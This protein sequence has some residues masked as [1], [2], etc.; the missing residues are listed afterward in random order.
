MTRS[1]KIRD[2]KDRKARE[3]AEQKQPEPGVV[4]VNQTE[5]AVVPTPIPFN[6]VQRFLASIEDIEQYVFG[7]VQDGTVIITEIDGHELAALYDGGEW[8]LG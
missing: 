7:D 5:M 4:E 1:E 3:A 6:H 8:S 2:T